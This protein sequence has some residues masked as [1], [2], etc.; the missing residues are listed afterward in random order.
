MA[1][2]AGYA[3][4]QHAEGPTREVTVKAQAR[5]ACPVSGAETGA[6]AGALSPPLTA[7][8]PQE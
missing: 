4:R 8:P 6:P 3:L 7:Y 2:L 1:P 5:K